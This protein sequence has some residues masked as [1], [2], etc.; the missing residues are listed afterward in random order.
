MILFLY[1]FL[2][3][4]F[5]TPWMALWG[6]RKRDEILLII[7]VNVLTN[8]LLNLSLVLCFSGQNIGM[9]IYLL[10]AIVVAAEYII[11]AI[12]FGFSA[13]LFLV[14]LSANCISYGLGE[15]IF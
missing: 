7:S 15:L 3:V 14:T 11:Y 2:T 12:P 4:L 13:K 5:E 1:A 9:L 8:L 6:Y 10:E